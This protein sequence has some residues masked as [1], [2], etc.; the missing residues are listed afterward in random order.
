[1]LSLN[2][3]GTAKQTLKQQHTLTG[4]FE[5]IHYIGNLVLYIHLKFVKLQICWLM[6]NVWEKHLKA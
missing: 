6:D 2:W 3:Q 1:M 4:D 5:I